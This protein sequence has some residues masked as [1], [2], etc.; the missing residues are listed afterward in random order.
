MV[1]IMDSPVNVIK[2][3]PG[4]LP[5]LL[6][7]IWEHI[8]GQATEECAYNLRGLG[9]ERRLRATNEPVNRT[10][11]NILLISKSF[12]VGTVL[13]RMFSK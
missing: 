2:E 1:P 4:P 6:D 9:K 3:N 7:K 8:L 5:D 10:R 13:S 11:R 12:Y